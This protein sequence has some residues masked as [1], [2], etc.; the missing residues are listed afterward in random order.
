[1]EEYGYECLD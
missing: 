1:D